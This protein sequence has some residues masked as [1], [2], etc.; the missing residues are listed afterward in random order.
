MICAGAALGNAPEE[1][2]PT[3]ATAVL[4]RS[5]RNQQMSA[6]ENQLSTARPCSLV[7][8]GVGRVQAASVTAMSGLSAASSRLSEMVT[9]M[10]ESG[11]VVSSVWLKPS[12]HLLHIS[13]TLL[14]SDPDAFDI[15]NFNIS[16]ANEEVNFQEAK[17]EYWTELACYGIV[18]ITAVTFWSFSKKAQPEASTPAD[19]NDFDHWQYGICFNRKVED[20][21][22]TQCSFH[23]CGMFCLACCC[24]SVR[25]AGTIRRVGFMGFWMAWGIYWIL[26]RGTKF[27][28]YSIASWC[29]AAALGTYFRQ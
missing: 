28:H 3:C 21:L 25:W 23:T 20:T 13:G 24:P 16:D 18:P 6:E 26:C 27:M 4:Q 1:V 5:V 9:S 29:L 19:P 14:R 22:C 12:L 2:D 11:R 17:I 8:A 10:T 15:N 7:D